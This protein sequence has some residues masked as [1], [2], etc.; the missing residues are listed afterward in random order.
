[1]ST[2]GGPGALL[3]DLDGVVTD[4][5]RAHEAAWRSTLQGHGLAFD[6]AAYARTRGRSRADSLTE[7]LVGRDVDAEAFATMLKEKD[8]AYRAAL[9]DL[10]PGD[11]LPGTAE[12]V[13]AAR[14]RGWPVAIAS[15]SRNAREVLD[16]LGLTDRFD[17]VADGTA[18]APKPAPDIFLA[19]AAAVDVPPAACVAVDDGAAGVEAALAAGMRVVGVG[20]AAEV[21]RAHVRV[22]TT[23]DLDLDRILA[24]LVG[25]GVR[26]PAPDGGSPR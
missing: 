14:R 11:V 9:A 8:A 3:L 6:A 25:P 5:A 2:T 21:G 1:V 19:A 23:A 13:L 26:G 12:L 18:G 15:S 20:P 17:A 16:R 22:A 24:A 7:L 4:T 10:G